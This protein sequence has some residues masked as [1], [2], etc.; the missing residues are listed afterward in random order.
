MYYPV[1]KNKLNELKGLGDVKS[2]IAST[3]IFELVDCKY[4]DLN[5]F[6]THSF[7]KTN[8]YL[9]ENN[10]FIDIPTYTKNSV[11]EMYE[12][13]Q[14]SSKFDFFVAIEDY[15]NSNGY[16]SFTPII[17]F[18]YNHKSI[19]SSIRKN[20]QFVKLI[21]EYF[22]NFAIRMFS[23][24]SYKNDDINLA[25]Q[26]LSFYGD[27]ILERCHFIFDTDSDTFSHAFN[28]AKELEE[29]EL[30]TNII[31]LGESFNNKS[32]LKRENQHDILENLQIKRV[33]YFKEHLSDKFNIEYADYTITDKIQSKIELEEGQ[34]FLY[35]PF[36]NYTIENGNQCKFTAAEKGNYEQYEGLC[37]DII[38]EISN[39]SSSHCEACEF[40]QNIA[41][42]E[43]GL[44]F[45]AGATWK[46]RMIA[47]HITMMAKL[48]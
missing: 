27:E 39:F 36:I 43:D 16:K 1:I 38:K 7:S 28:F 44:K 17:S 9:K 40:I 6:I 2:N 47:H 48:F 45:K 5:K 3:P 13:N 11:Y 15:F 21:A 46:Y 37:Q 10:C 23:D 32:R 26:V 24:Y 14:P 18:D 4:D 42:G 8:G 12:L 34:G 41:N 22:D 31:L 20:I 19:R 35:Y 30:F 33:D 25:D 29:D